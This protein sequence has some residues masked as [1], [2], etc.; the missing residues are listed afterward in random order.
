MPI[1]VL[2]AR[3]K[4]LPTVRTA[5]VVLYGI[6][7]YAPKLLRDPSAP[8]YHDEF[9]HW[10]ETDEI[11]QTGKLFRPN[12]IV[13]MAARYPGLHAATAALVHATGL[14]IWQAATILLLFCH[15]LLVVGILALAEILVTN[16]TASLAAIIYSLNSSFL[17]FDTQFGYESVGVTLV[18]WTLVAYT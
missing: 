2:I 5:L 3:R 12:P 11:L 17:Y 9:A 7:T 10:L 18:V 15:V 14:T 1:G 8:L 13:A 4:T 16:R 6:V